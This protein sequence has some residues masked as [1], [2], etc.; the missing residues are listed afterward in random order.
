MRMLATRFPVPG[1]LQARRLGRR[2]LAWG[3]AVLLTVAVPPA[4]GATPLEVRIS[5]QGT[6]FEVRAQA[7]LMAPLALV[8][9]TLTDYA[10]LP[11]FIP[12][13]KKSRVI[14]RDGSTTT[15][16]QVGEARFL[17]WT[18]PIEV[19]IE[20]I[21]HP[22]NIDVRLVSG[23]LRHLQGRFETEELREPARVDL[24]WMGTVEPA[25]ALPPLIGESLMR[26]L[27]RDQFVGMV[28]EI[29]RR[30]ALR[31]LGDPDGVAQPRVTPLP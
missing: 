29:E 3:L 13:M 27:I 1:T 9:A 6:R 17:F 14:G 30:E 10:H 26:Q 31:R 4:A 18:V 19:T 15:V 2:A 16:E 24:R 5:R 12:G 25:A 7:T 28:R 8:W 21:E 23:T 11:E 20:S 22:P